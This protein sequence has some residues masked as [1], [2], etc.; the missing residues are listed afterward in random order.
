MIVLYPLPPNFLSV[1]F[2]WSKQQRHWL[3]LK[4]HLIQATMK[5]LK[6]S[7]TEKRKLRQQA[8]KLYCLLQ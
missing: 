7:S 5:L 6:V 3:H 1:N 8:N 4:I 2:G